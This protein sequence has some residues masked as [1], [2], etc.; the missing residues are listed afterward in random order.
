MN[1]RL[2]A[3]YLG[4]FTVAIGGLM[5]PA[6]AWAVY[7][8]EWDALVALAFSI[9]VGSVV[10][11]LL[12]LLGRKAPDQMYQREA[13]T[14]VSVSWVVAAAVG[15]LPFIFGNVLG[16]VDAF[17]ESMSGFT[18]TG[19]T[20]IQDIE[21]CP[22]SIL[23]WRALTQWIGGMGI[24]VLFI[25]VLP[26]LGAGGKLLFRSEGSGPDPRGLSPHIK[27]TASLL[28][29]IYLGLTLV[30]TL[31]LM[32]TGLS[33]YDALSHTLTTLSTGGFSPNQASIAAYDSLA[34]E[35]II[36]VF[37]IV[38]GTSF[39]IFFAMLRGNWKAPFENTEWR[40]YISI[41]LIA[42]ALMSL[43][44]IFGSHSAIDGI[45][46]DEGYPFTKAVRSASF[47]VVSI[48]TGT[49]FV[50]E[51]FDLWPAFSRMLLVM[52]M[53]TG[54]CA[55][56]TAGGM[57]VVRIIMLAKMAYWSVEN[58]FRPKTIRAVR[59]GGEVVSVEVQRMVYAFL[60]LYVTWFVFGTLFMSALG[61]PFQTAASSVAATLN[62][63][64]PGLELVGAT[65]DF[66]GIPAAGKLFLTLCMALGRLEMFSICVLFIPS[67]WIHR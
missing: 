33:F 13:L 42:I 49:G 15:A 45:Q 14:L 43:N 46:T 19:S 22:K 1:Y 29:K 8:R 35:V 6:M 2:V 41:I 21:A 44:L 47:Q 63:I 65:R 59:I 53:F 54:A 61:L 5:L 10:G 57:K 9:L 24:V 51:D 52:L 16:P 26:Y 25:A 55:G 17:F 18:T 38:G 12:I 40:V 7:Y 11:G 62:N 50:T 66:S 4:F 39:A 37:M 23:F 64:G 30:E 36:I 67:F 20:V 3:R 56:S 28:Y 27:D 34:A 48:M 60:V 58:T 31:A 32:L